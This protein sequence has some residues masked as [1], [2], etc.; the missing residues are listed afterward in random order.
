MELW[1]RSQDRLYLNIVSNIA[2]IDNRV[3]ML[4]NQGRMALG[5][6]KTH[7]RALEI[8]DE[9]QDMINNDGAQNGEYDK[10]SGCYYV[11]KK[12][13]YEMPKE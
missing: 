1:I 3:E 6:Y 9:I 12:K 8:L 4:A 11:V 7:E 5:R 13:V 10:I 2:V